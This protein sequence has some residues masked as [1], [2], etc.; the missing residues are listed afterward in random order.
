MNKKQ[1]IIAWTMG[2]LVS[3]VL[4]TMNINMEIHWAKEMEYETGYTV[5]EPFRINFISNYHLPFIVQRL[6]KFVLP[7]F[8]MGSL[9]I[10]TLRDKA[11]VLMG[12]LKDEKKE[13]LMMRGLKK[14][15]A[16]EGLVLLLYILILLLIYS[17]WSNSLTSYNDLI[18]L[19]VF[20]YVPYL[21]VKFVLWA[22]R[23]LTKDR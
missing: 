23:I 20:F 8:I 15:I 1:L 22:Y 16:R 11:D 7:I 6:F 10:Y 21:I 19:F 14:F 18:V 12:A 3:I 4:L 17:A 2:V 5:T 13:F 9:L